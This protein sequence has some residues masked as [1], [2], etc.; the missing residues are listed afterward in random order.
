MKLLMIANGYAS[1]TSGGGAH[2]N[3]FLNILTN[4]GYDCS[5]VMPSVDDSGEFVSAVKAIK[6]P[7]F[8]FEQKV[9]GKAPLLFLIYCY[10]IF[11]SAIILISSRADIFVAV[12]G[13]FQDVFPFVFSRRK[14]SVFVTFIHHIIQKQPRTGLFGHFIKILES[15]SFYILRSRGFIVFTGSEKVRRS[16]ISDYKFR[17]DLIRVVKN[18]IDL[19][20]IN[21]IQVSGEKRFDLAFCGRLHRS[22]GI[23]DLLE[24]V[25]CLRKKYADIRVVV[26][27]GGLEE[28]LLRK[29]VERLGLEENVV[30]VGYVSEDE[31]IRYL[32]QSRVF[33]LPSHEEGWGIVIGEAMACGLPVV[34]Y[35]LHDIVDIWKDN[36]R[37]VDC[38]DKE[39]FGS[40]IN[41][42]L[43]SED[44]VADYSRRGC[45]FV[46]GLDWEKIIRDE[47]KFIREKY[48]ASTSEV[49]I[50]EHERG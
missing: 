44:K 3:N 15:A 37:W 46:K 38:F 36:V 6:Y 28:P 7:S 25:V 4:L 17:D 49:D 40:E 8:P 50:S 30:L 29:E 5:K 10:R 21:R 24:I 35:R 31:K 11:L 23:Y 12:S 43:D 19:K 42:L 48:Q 18:G 41:G 39:G 2:A 26:V 32:K 33:V 9:Y 20:R 1:K 16:L 13:Q 34:V 27:G 22:K 14:K 47:E 45:E